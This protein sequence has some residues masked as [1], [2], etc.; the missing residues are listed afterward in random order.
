MQT[1]TG[2]QKNKRSSVRTRWI[3]LVVLVLLTAAGAL[4][5]MNRIGQARES[6]AAQQAQT[7]EVVT[8][9][10][11]WL[12]EIP[13]ILL[14]SGRSFSNSRSKPAKAISP[15]PCTRTST[16]GYRDR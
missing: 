9:F 7:G 8:V 14:K 11:D 12:K 6:L 4:F 5:V 15:S 13:R 3:V 2:K 1:A 10:P 16:N